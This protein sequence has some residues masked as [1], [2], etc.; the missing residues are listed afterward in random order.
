MHT[1]HGSLAW[2]SNFKQLEGQLARWIEKLQEF[3]YEIVH[4]PGHRHKNANALSRLSCNQCG[5]SNHLEPSLIATTV[6]DMS[7]TLLQHHSATELRYS[8]LADPS[9]TIILPAIEKQQK[10]TAN[11]LQGC[12]PEVRMKVF[13]LWDQ[14]EVRDG[15]LWR[16]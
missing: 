13:Q 7:N 14:L 3:E 8:Q 4:H 6:T 12:S 2:L 9:I 5:R 10:P 15:L 1:D 16:K 11:T